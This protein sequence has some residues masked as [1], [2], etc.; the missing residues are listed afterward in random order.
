M[1]GVQSALYTLV[2][3]PLSDIDVMG[4]MSANI[5]LLKNFTTFFADSSL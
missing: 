4:M 2:R 3:T 1:E 5:E